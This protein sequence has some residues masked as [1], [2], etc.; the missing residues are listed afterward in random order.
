MIGGDPDA[1]SAVLA[2][3]PRSD[4]PSLL[5][6]AALLSSD[7]AHLVRGSQLASSPRDR[8]LLVLVD[9]LLRDD[10][11]LFDGLVRD[12]LA[13]HPDHLLAAWMA[14]QPPW[15]QPNRRKG[16]EMTMISEAPPTPTRRSTVRILARWLM[17]FAGFPLGG[18]AAM[19]LTGPVDSLPSAL[20]G[21]FVTGLVLG[22][23]QA[24]ALRADPRLFFRW[25]VAT[26][27]GL[28][29][30][31]AGGAALVGFATGLGDLML[32]GAISGLVV[33]LAQAITLWPRIGRIAAI[34]PAYLAGAWAAGWAVSTAIGVR[35]EQRFTVFGSTGALTVT[36]LTCVLP[37]LLNHHR[38]PRIPS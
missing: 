37:V 23:V 33:G 36:L 22:A 6:A 14:G 15:N 35:V 8:Q 4:D 32:Q 1:V 31:L 34:W 20:A 7:R 28:S 19:L 38:T 21:G 16:Q 30:G 25:V 9:A 11:D 5:A 10:A 18:S 27:T 13:D 26:A 2:A 12:H 29:A 3:A 17:S 24:W